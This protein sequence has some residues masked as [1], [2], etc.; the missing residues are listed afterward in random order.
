[1]DVAVDVA[2]DVTV[3]VVLLQSFN[4]VVKVR[5]QLLLEKQKSQLST[6][7]KNLRKSRMRKKLPRRLWPLSRK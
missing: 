2:V 7:S 4:R 6:L 3:D 1:M 5:L